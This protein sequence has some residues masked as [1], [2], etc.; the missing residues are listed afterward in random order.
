MSPW[1]AFLVRLRFYAQF[2]VSITLLLHSFGHGTAAQQT[3]TAVGAAVSK[4]PQAVAIVQN[5]LAAMRGAS[6]LAAYQDSV[7]NG[8]VVVYM[9]NPSPISMPIVLKSKGLDKTRADVQT[10]HGQVTRTVNMGIGARQRADGTIQNLELQNTLA[11]TVEHIPLVSLGKYSDTNMSIEYLGSATLDGKAVDIVGFHPLVVS[12]ISKTDWDQKIRQTK[13]YVDT[14]ISVVTKIAYPQFGENHS[15]SVTQVEVLFTNY[16]DMSG[17]LVPLTQTTYF[18]GKLES[19]LQ[20]DSVAF[21]VGL[22]DAEFEPPTV[23]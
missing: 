5:A 13:Y 18:D 4:D 2:L 3:T 22:P 6:A 15:E 20:L 1:C 7:A 21:N 12:A 23:K 10:P 16:K 11:Q 8:T 19:I 9:N 14:G 17:I